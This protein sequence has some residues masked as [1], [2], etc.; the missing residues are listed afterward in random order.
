MINNTLGTALKIFRY[1]SPGCIERW[2]FG[3]ATN[4]NSF[5]HDTLNANKMNLGPGGDRQ[6]KM[7]EGFDHEHGLPHSMVFQS[8]HPDPI[9]RG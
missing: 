4:H 6:P 9:L 1:A 3:N 8:N 7:R 5:A 2:A